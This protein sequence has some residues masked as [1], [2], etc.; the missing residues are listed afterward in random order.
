MAQDTS[1]YNLKPEKPPISTPSKPSATSR[2]PAPH[3][4]NKPSSVVTACCYY[5]QYNIYWKI[6]TQRPLGNMTIKRKSMATSHTPT[7]IMVLKT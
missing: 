7:M 4:K 3:K 2:E 6:P 5:I 1:I